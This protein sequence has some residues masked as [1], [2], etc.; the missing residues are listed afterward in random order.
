VGRTH[1]NAVD[2]TRLNTQS[3]K[4][5]LAVVDRVASD[6][7]AFATFDFFFADVDTID[8]ARLC[9]LIARDTGRQIKAVIPTV[10]SSHRHGQFWVFEVFG[11]RFS[12]GIV[13]L[14]PSSQR[15][16]HSMKNSVNSFDNITKPRKD[17]LEPRNHFYW[18]SSLPPEVGRAINRFK[19]LAESILA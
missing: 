17:S 19:I 2:R 10:A 12:L 14:K 6:L 13:R 4:H 11:K 1:E 9:T 7:K 18:G 8:R 5:A 15:H 3:A 16:P